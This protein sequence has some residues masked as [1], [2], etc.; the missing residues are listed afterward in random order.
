M[1]ERI[2]FNLWLNEWIRSINGVGYNVRYVFPLIQ[3][4]LLASFHS[5]SFWK[6][7]GKGRKNWGVNGCA[8]FIYET[9]HS[10]SSIKWKRLT[11]AWI[12]LR[13]KENGGAA[14]AAQQQTKI[15]EEWIYWVKLKQCAGRGEQ[16]F[17]QLNFFRCFPLAPACLNLF[18]LSLSAMA[19][20]LLHSRAELNFVDCLLSVAPS[21]FLNHFLPSSL[22][23]RKWWEELITIIKELKWMK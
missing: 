6:R 15:N 7:S 20:A 14:A 13:R 3:Y 4:N 10:I 2:N 5:H 16:R 12:W 22:R 17:N 11:P 8:T 9:I 18:L 23:F 21:F 1:N 19:S